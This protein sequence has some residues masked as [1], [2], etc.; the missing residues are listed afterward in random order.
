MLQKQNVMS[1]HCSMDVQIKILKRAKY[2]ILKHKCDTLCTALV[3]ALV[4]LCIIETKAET[5]KKWYAQVIISKVVPLITHENAVLYGDAIK[6]PDET[7]LWWSKMNHISG[8]NIK[9]RID[10][11]DWAI[12]TIYFFSRNKITEHL[13]PISNGKNH[14]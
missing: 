3:T 4:Q 2:L 13:K 7:G 12:D 10:F 8:R 14:C 9:P 6:E 11:L 1:I 5:R